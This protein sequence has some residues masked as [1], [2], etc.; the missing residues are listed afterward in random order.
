MNCAFWGQLEEYD[1]HIAP[2]NV[3]LHAAD[4]LVGLSLK[5]TEEQVE[6]I[7][8]FCQGLKENPSANTSGT[9]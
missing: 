4:R 1:P 8:H 5:E 6:M 7:P 9:H 3:K 2:V